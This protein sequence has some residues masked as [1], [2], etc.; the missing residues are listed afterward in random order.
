M[1]VSPIKQTEVSASASLLSRKEGDAPVSTK[2]FSLT[3]VDLLKTAGVR[4]ESGFNV[5][6]DREGVTTLP[7]DAERILPADDAE[8]HI[9]DDREPA[10]TPARE[11][12]Y[13]ED[14]RPPPEGSD[15]DD[16]GAGETRSRDDTLGGEPDG[17]ASRGEESARGDDHGGHEPSPEDKPAAE[18]PAQNPADET[19]ADGPADPDTAA[20]AEDIATPTATTATTPDDAATRHASQVLAGLLAVA[21]AANLPGEGEHGRGNAVDG[22]TT[23]LAAVGKHTA[24]T[25]GNAGGSQTNTNAHQQGQPQATAHH[26][27]QPQATAH[28]PAQAGA[29]N[30]APDTGAVQQAAS[31]SRLL[32]E[33]SPLAVRVNVA[34]A[35]T[36][37]SQPASTLAAATAT[38]AQTAAAA[39]HGQPPS[40]GPVAVAINPAATAATGPGGQG[41]AVQASAAATATAPAAAPPAPLVNQAAPQGQAL[42]PDGSPIPSLPGSTADTAPTRNTTPAQ[43]ANA[44]R[45]ASPQSVADQVSVNITRAIK[46]GVD[47]IDIQLKPASLGRINV[48]LEIGHDGRVQ[49]V[50]SADNKDTLDLLQRESR[51][52]ERALQDAGLQTN[53][54]DLS[55]NLRQQEG[56][57]TAADEAN[58][59]AAAEAAPLDAEAGEDALYS[60]LA[61]EWRDGIRPDGRIDIRA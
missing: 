18:A 15:D 47:K 12:A 46:A 40:H 43:A 11:T 56:Q 3:F 10:E 31:L 49:A 25:G 58:G 23:A 4:I 29:G 48:Q 32:G 33:G 36:V 30:S 27:G 41:Q 53:A 60:A 26:Q 45:P 42:A 52:L 50:V 20:A 6:T 2:D 39:Q 1:D 17:Y 7:D 38:A 54:G 16:R 61:T 14:D 19:A 55:F 34:N 35:P 9:D 59:P 8:R 24:A 37:V 5:L 28:Q 22:L 44:Q 51:D 13:R 21:Q 57:E